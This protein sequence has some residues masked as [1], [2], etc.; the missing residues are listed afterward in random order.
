MVTNGVADGLSKDESDKPLDGDQLYLVPLKAVVESCMV[1]PL[2]MD[3]SGMLFTVGWC[4]IVIVTESL[5]EQPFLSVTLTLYLVV[6][7]G[8]AVGLAVVLSLKPKPGDHL[9]PSPLIK[10][11]VSCT[12]APLHTAVSAMVEM[13]GSGDTVTFTESTA[14][15]PITFLPVT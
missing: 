12:L 7:K 8:D 3:V 11:V 2:H 14:G 4:N 15:Q 10:V 9:Y 13:T 5:S 1:V 6:T